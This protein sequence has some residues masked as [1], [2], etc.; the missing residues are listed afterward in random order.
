[1]NKGR[2]QFLESRSCVA[3]VGVYGVWGCCFI[4]LG[5]FHKGYSHMQVPRFRHI[6]LNPLELDTL[7][8]SSPPPPRPKLVFNSF[9]SDRDHGH[10]GSSCV[11]LMSPTQGA[12]GG[13]G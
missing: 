11:H 3:G 8:P 5:N 12:Q 6:G 13:P 7:N 10:A 4:E 1:M 9:G 2:E